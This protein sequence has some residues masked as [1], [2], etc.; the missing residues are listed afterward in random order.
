MTG[1]TLFREVYFK[2]ILS[3]L[4]VI[5][6]MLLLQSSL[7]QLKLRALVAEATSSR[8]QISSETIERAILRAEALGFSIDEM[9]GLQDLIGRERVRDRSVVGIHIVSPI[10][11][12]ILT[13]GPDRLPEDDR[14][15]VL[16]RVLGSGDKITR[17]DLG[18]RLYTGRLLHDSS[19]AVM[20]AVIMISPTRDIIQQS[21]MAFARMTTAY[22]VIFAA[23]AVLV[24]PFIIFQFSSLRHAYRALAP[25]ALD[26]GFSD[27]GQTPDTEALR[28]VI[29]KGQ[30]A[31][32]KAENELD[33]LLADG[34]ETG[35]G[36]RQATDPPRLGTNGE[37]AA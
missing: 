2:V 24:V 5:G 33:Q 9:V 11:V 15:A 1:W 23:I 12:P 27:A 19:D 36:G 26:S 14:D 22:L 37:T 35:S 17:L 7:N 29:A 32:A 3:I 4:A 21:R 10:G 8:L 34:L 28:A 25:S 30:T 20:G 31:F 16:R 13:T 18:A 6:A